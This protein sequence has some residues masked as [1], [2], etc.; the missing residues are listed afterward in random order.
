MKIAGLAHIIKPFG[1]S[2]RYD[3]RAAIMGMWEY[4]LNT[5][6]VSLRLDVTC[7]GGD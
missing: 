4:V 7:A 6:L 3:D 2:V 5:L 1:P